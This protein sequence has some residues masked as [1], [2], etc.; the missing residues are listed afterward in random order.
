MENLSSNPY[1]FK[2]GVI[3]CRVS[4]QKQVDNGESL[5]HQEH[6]CKTWCEK[7]NIRIIKNNGEWSF[8]DEGV[9]GGKA[10]DLD[11]ENEKHK[12]FAR[13]LDP[14]CKKIPGIH[15][16][17]GLVA[18]LKA[19]KKDFIFVTY[20]MTRLS[21]N[22]TQS[23]VITDYLKSKKIHLVCIQDNI[24]TVGKKEDQ[25]VQIHLQSLFAQMEHNAI[26]Q[27]TK[28]TLQALKEQGRYLGR[29]RYG[30][31]LENGQ[32]YDDL[33][34]EPEEQKVIKLMKELRDTVTNRFGRPV[35]YYYI[36][37]YLNNQGYR[38]RSGK[39][40]CHSHVEY[41]CKAPPALLK[42][43]PKKRAKFGKAKEED[44]IENEVI[45]SPVI[46]KEV[47]QLVRAEIGQPLL[48]IKEEKIEI[49]ETKETY[50]LENET[51]KVIE[52]KKK[53]SD[54][55]KEKNKTKDRKLKKKKKILYSSSSDDSDSSSDE[56]IRK[57]QKKL[58]IL[59]LKAKKKKLKKQMKKSVISDS[60]EQN[61][62]S[63]SNSESSPE[64]I[65]KKKKKEKIGIKE[66][67]I[68][69]D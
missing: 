54:S 32:P 68:E 24:D 49:K 16:R 31:K 25:S 1:Q 8:K 29:I 4:T 63:E 13:T 2:F 14:I 37:E 38:T 50:I 48:E 5:S 30:Y 39:N 55:E 7:N 10:N 26:K 52:E 59:K 19:C 45:E 17:P 40:W 44:Y 27:R 22:A 65:K 21:R 47:E 69:S 18:G 6:I 42:G 28:S 56:D 23:L 43:N 66:T 61:S 35:S 9:S 12:V 67:I 57:L 15:H 20:S 64:K 60:S 53:E 3:Y 46:H 11:D 36:A 51:N 34:E 62:E 41:I 58:E 33:V